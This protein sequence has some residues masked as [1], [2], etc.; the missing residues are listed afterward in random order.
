MLA[1]VCSFLGVDFEQQMVDPKSFHE[2][3]RSMPHHAHL[4][5]PIGPQRTDGYKTRLSEE[6]IALY[7]SHA[8]EAM[9]FFGYRPHIPLK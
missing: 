7:E 4:Y 8:S 6:Q 9:Q 2:R 1:S 3:Y 5:Q